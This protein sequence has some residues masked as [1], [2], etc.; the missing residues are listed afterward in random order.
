MIRRTRNL[1]N[2]DSLLPNTMDVGV[3]K[4]E[5]LPV[6]ALRYGGAF[7]PTSS[8][9]FKLNPL[10]CHGK[11]GLYPSDIRLQEKEALQNRLNSLNNT[12]SE[13]MQAHKRAPK[14]EEWIPVQ[15]D[16][17]TYVP[18]STQTPYQTP[19]TPLPTFSPT[20]VATHP[21]P[22]TIVATQPPFWQWRTTIHGK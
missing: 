8:I 6:R 7:Y 9:A 1:C 2:C 11:S 22:T 15:V 13:H 3:L 17:T 12:I 14:R 10:R 19:I 18:P 20:T 5:N 16:A 4:S 21:P